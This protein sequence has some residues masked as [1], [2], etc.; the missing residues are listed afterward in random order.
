ME[1]RM[2]TETV[3]ESSSINTSTEYLQYKVLQQWNDP[4]KQNR[5]GI[6]KRKPDETEKREQ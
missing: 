5:K 6:G 3:K 4:P 1:T 2:E